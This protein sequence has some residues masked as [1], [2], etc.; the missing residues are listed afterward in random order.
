[1]ISYKKSIKVNYV[2]DHLKNNNR[3]NLNN[4][5]ANRGNFYRFVKPTFNGRHSIFAFITSSGYLYSDVLYNNNNKVGGFFSKNFRDPDFEV[6]E[7]FRK[8]FSDL[9]FFMLK[10]NLIF[11]NSF[12]IIES[13]HGNLLLFM[14]FKK[15]YLK[16]LH[17]YSSKKNTKFIN[18][19]NKLRRKYKKNIYVFK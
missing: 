11:F 5:V 19:L 18:S 7:G 16:V 4:Y 12:N 1:M 17:K 15:E 6:Y 3:L 8:T 2:L 10:R 13:F 14:R 9:L